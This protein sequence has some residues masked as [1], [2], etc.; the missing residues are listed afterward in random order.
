[1]N[2]AA[3]AGINM[4][5]NAAMNTAMNS[6]MN[7]A[8]NTATDMA[9]NTAMKPFPWIGVLVPLLLLLTSALPAPA[10]WLSDMP[11]T[12]HQPNGTAVPCFM[13]GD[14]YFRWAHD[15]D[16]FVIT[17]D[18]ADGRLVY[19]VA[20]DGR[21]APTAWA[22]GDVD[23]LAAG[24]TPRLSI[25]TEDVRRRVEFFRGHT[26]KNR[27]VDRGGPKVGQFNNIVVFVRFAGET[28]FADSI[29]LYDN[30]YNARGDGANSMLR[31]FQDVSYGQLSL[32]TSFF[33][34]STSTVVSYQDS[35]QRSFF[36]PRSV[37]NP[38]GYDPANEGRQ[39]AER[40]H[41]MLV[42]AVTAISAQVPADLNI[43]QNNDDFVDN[44][45]F[46]AKGT[47]D[48]WADM[49]WPHMWALLYGDEVF[50]NGKRVW[51]YNLQLQDFLNRP[52]AGN[53]VLCHEM[54][55]SLG[56]PDLYRYEEGRGT[57]MPVGAWDLMEGTRNPPQ[58]M[59]SYMK[60]RY[61]GWIPP[62]PL[63]STGGVYSLQPVTSSA[64][65]CY[66]I[67]S[68]NATDQYYVVEYRSRASSLFESRLPGTGLIVYR[69]NTAVT[70]STGNMYGPPDEVYVYRPGGSNSVTGRID[71]ACF[72]ADSSRTSM[73]DATD[74][75]GFL[76]DG[77]PGGLDITQIGPAGATITFTVNNGAAPSCATRPGDATG[78]GFVTVTDVTTTVSDI[79]Q[80]EPLAPGARACA[81]IAP[82]IG[83]VDIFD[84]I[85]IVDLIL[86]PGAPRPVAVRAPEGR[87]SQPLYVRAERAGGTWRLTFDGSGL[88]GI[89]AE[90]PLDAAPLVPPCLD[91]AASGV[92]INW[93][94][95]R[96]KLRLLAYATGGGPLAPGTC[97]LAVPARLTGGEVADGLVTDEDLV[98]DGALRLSSAPALL[99]AGAD[100]S[101]LPFVLAG[102][103]GVPGLAPHSRIVALEPNPTRG[104]VRLCLDG[105]SPG[106]VAGVRACDAAGRLVAGFAAPPAAAD[107]RVAVEW[108]GRNTRGM[109]LPT[110]VY[111][112]ILDGAAGGK[113]VKLLLLR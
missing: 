83:S 73:T 79:L 11:V 107:G 106:S 17:E 91:G 53:G 9:M 44:V 111:F 33:P 35:H 99:F 76:A 12:L 113:G 14:E 100:G 64:N 108:D 40:L 54:F 29:S 92:A 103:G 62:L 27:P 46:I 90:L 47:S 13:T 7:T 18:P 2:R 105:L 67:D 101:S 51:T 24:L 78:D 66:R 89:Q 5:T 58:H 20:R 55:H 30:M 97:T 94:F 48:N 69:V 104:A 50:I 4:A 112:L 23:P 49:L 52:Q 37:T 34:M 60:Y 98:L 110:G 63:I 70:D 39:G 56:A 15:A 93:D 71:E 36:S 16:G 21:W 87:S 72:S 32:Q 80:T 25:P 86:H 77:R 95:Q 88:A 6:A 28:E 96:G 85:A 22:V 102:D 31:Y 10:A 68:P 3:N 8:M 38:L 57:F 42:S 74:P 1:M 82:V 109:P 59:T 43:D 41:A 75:S 81:D 26:P 84:V 19:A 61:G 45:C 65:N